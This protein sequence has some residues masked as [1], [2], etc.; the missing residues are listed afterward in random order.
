MV[1]YLVQALQL[2]SLMEAGWRE[3]LPLEVVNITTSPESLRVYLTFEI[4]DEKV[5]LFSRVLEKQNEMEDAHEKVHAQ[6]SQEAEAPA[7]GEGVDQSGGAKKGT[8]G[9]GEGGAAGEG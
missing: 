3:L 5:E 2:H 1:K 9:P 8:G 4:P 7:A 6:R